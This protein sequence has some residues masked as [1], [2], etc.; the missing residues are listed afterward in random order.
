Q[1]QPKARMSLYLWDSMH[2]NPNARRVL[3]EF[4]QVFSFDRSDVEQNKKMQFLPLFYG[5]EF[6]RSA[7]WQGPS[8]YD[9]CF[10]GTIHTDRYKVLEKVIANLEARGHTV[11]VFCCYP[12][13]P[14][15]YLRALIDP[16][17]RRFGRK[18][19]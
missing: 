9:A 5:R 19:V 3:G 14:L 12:S 13:R 17:F 18:Y 15:F 2:Y 7:N 10:I 11:F 8:I 6:E 4:D 16:G 1:A